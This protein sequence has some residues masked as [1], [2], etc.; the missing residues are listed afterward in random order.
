MAPKKMELVGNSSLAPIAQ[1]DVEV[2]ARVLTHLD[3]ALRPPGGRPGAGRRG[4]R[5]AICDL[6]QDRAE[7]SLSIRVIARLVP[8]AGRRDP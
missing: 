5:V 6:D 1:V 7:R 2:L 8:S 4:D 3:F